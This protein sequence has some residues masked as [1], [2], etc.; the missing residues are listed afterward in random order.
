MLTGLDRRIVLIS[1]LFM[2]PVVGGLTTY[3][4][5][6]A[7]ESSLLAPKNNGY[8]AA[9]YPGGLVENLQRS[10]V[11]I[12]CK[13]S[14][15]SGFSFTLD[16]IDLN[17]G[18]RFAKVNTSGFKSRL[19]TNA[20]VIQDCLD[21]NEVLFESADG[22]TYVATIEILDTKNDLAL[23]GSP[24]FIDGI[25]GVY[26]KPRPGYWVMGLGSPHNFAGSVTFGHIINLDVRSVFHT[27][28]LSPGNSGGPLV[29][30]EGYLFG[31]NSGSKPVGQ[32]FNFS[33]SL[34]SFCEMLVKCKNGSFWDK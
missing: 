3:V 11:T 22:K 9:K 27:A 8:S 29:D 10:L 33:I 21:K 15:G 18:Y 12:S 2:L 16:K 24:I 34:N 20:H 23:L 17:N 14:Q 6:Q 30:N 31:V 7:Q 1:L 25:S 26:W 13:S 28:S 4:V 32:N 5:Q 19:I